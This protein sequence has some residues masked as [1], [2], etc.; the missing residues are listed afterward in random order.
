[1]RL[2][3]ILAAALLLYYLGYRWLVNQPRQKRIQALLVVT[4]L[5]L[6][7]LVATGRAS[8]IFALLGAAL[9]F[10]R[11]VMTLLNYL[12]LVQ[13]LYRQYG[14]GSVASSGQQSTVETRFLRLM[15]DHDS[16]E[17]SGTVLEGAFAGRTLAEL[18]LAQLLQLLSLC[19]QQ[20]QESAQLL[21]AY[22]DRTQTG[23]WRQ[24]SG[25]ES[26]GQRSEGF[27]ES[28]DRAEALQILGLEE[29]AGEDQIR[30]AHRRLMQKLHPDRGGS[31]YL[32]WKINQAKTVLL[33]DA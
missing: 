19:R 13:R 10:L 23:D 25:T 18:T 29:G 20:D 7:G 32:A 28:M 15:L 22:L 3:L 5:V 21:E 1:M 9:P 27:S 16:G 17:M 24:Q 26:G 14:G 31:T 8:W 11:R 2:L 12:P 33:D 4:G 30:D 6:I